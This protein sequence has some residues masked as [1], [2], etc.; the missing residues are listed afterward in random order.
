MR[1][2][3]KH[4]LHRAFWVV[5]HSRDF[6]DIGQYQIG[7]LVGGKTTRKPDRQGIRTESTFQLLQ[8]RPRL[9]AARSL[10]DSA[11]THKLDHAR[12]QVKMGLPKFAV[13]DVINAFPYLG[14][15]AAQMPS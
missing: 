15:A 14:F 9:I 7:A 2:A 13:I 5:D 10:L 6:F 12:L 8:H 1:L 3:G 11:A 4:E